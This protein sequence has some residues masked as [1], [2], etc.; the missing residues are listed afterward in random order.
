VIGPQHQSKLRN[1]RLDKKLETITRNPESIPRLKR[2]DPPA[3]RGILEPLG[4]IHK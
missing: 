3:K 2:C 1:Q 4:T